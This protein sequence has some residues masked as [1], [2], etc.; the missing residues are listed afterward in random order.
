MV[1][2]I[3]SDF[4]SVASSWQSLSRG[5]LGHQGSF[6]SLPKF[7]IH[8]LLSTFLEN[9]PFQFPKLYRLCFSTNS[10]LNRV[11]QGLPLATFQLG[12]FS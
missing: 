2:T 7:K 12:E 3:L 11:S 4:K 5:Y 10:I 9:M 1:Y 6:L 8:L